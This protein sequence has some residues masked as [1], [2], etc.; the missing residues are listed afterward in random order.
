LNSLERLDRDIRILVALVTVGG[1]G[2]LVIPVSRLAVDGSFN[3]FTSGLLAILIVGLL[4]AW[5]L[6]LCYVTV[7]Q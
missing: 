7:K 2:V 6:Y 4:F 1:L 5:I 3:N